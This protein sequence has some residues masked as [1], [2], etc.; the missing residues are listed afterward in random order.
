[1]EVKNNDAQQVENLPGKDDMI[2]EFASNGMF[3]DFA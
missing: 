3:G 1:V 2:V